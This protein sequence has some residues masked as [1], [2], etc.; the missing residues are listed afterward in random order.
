[1]AASGSLLAFGGGDF[2]KFFVTHAIF[3]TL[4]IK[5]EQLKESC[6]E[7]IKPKAAEV[8]CTKIL[9]YFLI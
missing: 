9:R 8:M 3:C 7:F 6:L 4:Q 5:A 1:M 2:M